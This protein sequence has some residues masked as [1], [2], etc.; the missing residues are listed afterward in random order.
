M[1]FHSDLQFWPGA[2]DAVP[3]EATVVVMSAALIPAATMMFFFICPPVRL[4]RDAPLIQIL[5]LATDK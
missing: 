1:V 5:T 4:L 3:A 2:A